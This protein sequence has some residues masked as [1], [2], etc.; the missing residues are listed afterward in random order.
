MVEQG[1]EKLSRTL[2]SIQNRQHTHIHTER[3][4]EYL[5][6]SQHV[7]EEQGYVIQEQRLPAGGC[8]IIRV[9]PPNNVVI[10]F[11]L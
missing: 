5:I 3:S 11:A 10:M 2:A 8:L 1:E 9:G 4:V 7:M 6:P